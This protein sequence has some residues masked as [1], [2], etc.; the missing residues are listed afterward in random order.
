MPGKHAEGRTS[1]A[2]AAAEQPKQPAAAETVA[3]EMPGTDTN[4]PMSEA[5]FKA[6]LDPREILRRRRTEGSANPEEVE[7]MLESMTAEVAVM[8]DTNAMRAAAIEQSMAELDT[9]FA[10]FLA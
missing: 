2:A 8:K 9:Q 6:S 3:K 1:D 7:K 10:P 4:C 5:E